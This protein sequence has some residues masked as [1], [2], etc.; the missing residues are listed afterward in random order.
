[1]NDLRV[2]AFCPICEWIM[3][4]P[5]SG[6][7]YYRFGC[8]EDCYIQFVEGREE[9]WT[10]GWR[11]DREQLDRWLSARSRPATD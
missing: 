8:C 1:M 10:S 5:K 3:R 2:P 4:A 11:P 7:M 9:R 6:S